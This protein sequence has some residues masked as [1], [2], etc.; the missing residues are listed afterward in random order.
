MTADYILFDAFRPEQLDAISRAFELSCDRLGA[1]NRK[2][3]FVE[4]YW[5]AKCR[6]LWFSSIL[7]FRA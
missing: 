7:Y 5:T 1:K 6:V 4:V 2:D 3:A